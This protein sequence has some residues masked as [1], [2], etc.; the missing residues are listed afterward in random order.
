M[1][2]YFS[3]PERKNEPYALPDVETFYVGRACKNPSKEIGSGAEEYGGVGWYWSCFPG[4]LPDE[5]W[6]P[7]NTEAKALEDARNY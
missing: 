5:A 4:C 3:D 7:F 6:G 2:Q 1:A